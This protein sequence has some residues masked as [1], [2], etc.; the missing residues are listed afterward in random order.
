M[1]KKQSGFSVVEGLLVIV[2]V[3][4]LIFVGW[5]A[6]KARHKDDNTSSTTST[7][8]Q[9]EPA[10]QDEYAGWK[11]YK[12]SGE[13]FTIKYPSDWK[14]STGGADANG[15]YDASKDQAAFTGPNGFSVSYDVIKPVTSF[16]CLGNCR[17]TVLNE[18]MLKD[19]PGYVVINSSTTN[20]NI[21]QQMLS[22]SK[23]KTYEGQADQ[24]WP[25]YN[26]KDSSQFVRWKGEY[27]MQCK[28]E[29][30]CDLQSMGLDEFKQKPEVQTGIKI[31]RSIIY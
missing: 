10:K 9:Q 31:L 23:A 11:T 3:A 20:G 2:V 15:K 27:Q 8:K 28:S 22:I 4:I 29:G 13:G 1:N 30:N 24:G 17:F 19:T 12:S 25:Y 7:T 6:W 14:L 26:A 5:Y 16:N 18:I 21:Y